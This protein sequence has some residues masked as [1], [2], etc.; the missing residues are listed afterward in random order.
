M[1]IQIA[2]ST[3]SHFHWESRRDSHI[4]T[5][6]RL[7]LISARREQT[8]NYKVLPMLPSAPVLGGSC[9]WTCWGNWGSETRYRH[10]V[11]RDE[12]VGRLRKKSARN[13]GSSPRVSFALIENGVLIFAQLVAH[14]AGGGCGWNGVAGL[15]WREIGPS[16]YQL[17]V[18]DAPDDDA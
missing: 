12:E 16:F 6:I 2:D 10:R 9:G 3:S 1:E 7:P 8:A 14:G 5:A 13:I 17:T 11:F 15:R 18:G 4:P